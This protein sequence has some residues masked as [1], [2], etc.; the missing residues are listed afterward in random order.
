MHLVKTNNNNLSKEIALILTG[1]WLSGSTL[2]RCSE[3]GKW[4]Y[5]N[6][7]TQEL[8][9][10]KPKCIKVIKYSIFY[11]ILITLENI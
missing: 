8:N 5:K 9:G 2:S 10:V 7:T 1:H 6:M 4:L 11:T 3:N